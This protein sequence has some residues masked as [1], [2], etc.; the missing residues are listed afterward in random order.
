MYIYER[1]KNMEFSELLNRIAQGD[2][3]A[4][5]EIYA[6]IYKQLYYI[7]YFSLGNADD[8]KKTLKRAAQTCFQKCA[9]CKSKE[10]FKAY[11]IRLL[12]DGIVS[13]FKACRKSGRKPVLELDTSTQTGQKFA[14]LTE[15]ERLTFVIWCFTNYSEHQ[16]SIVTGLKEEVA[17]QKLKSAKSKMLDEQKK[18]TEELYL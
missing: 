10:T 3:S 6:P 18:Q 4:F 17:E 16:L 1:K 7:A 14:S 9:D 2:K 13:D 8:A 12:C 5:A 15:A 11:F